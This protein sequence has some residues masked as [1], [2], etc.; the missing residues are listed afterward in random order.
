MDPM[1][2][3]LL[4]FVT[5]VS[6]T[7]TLTIEATND[8]VTVREG[9]PFSLSCSI[10]LGFPGVRE[11]RWYRGSDQMLY[12]SIS[13]T[14]CGIKPLCQE[15]NTTDNRGV[16]QF[17]RGFHNAATLTLVIDHSTAHDNTS[18][19]CG[20]L[21]SSNTFPRSDNIHVIVQH[22]PDPSY[23]MCLR[24]NSSTNADILSFSCW[25]EI[26]QPVV[27]LEW[28]VEGS[29]SERIS[30]SHQTEIYE[31]RVENTLFLNE[32]GIP[33]G[34]LVFTCHMTSS[35]FPQIQ[36]NCSIEPILIPV[37]Q[38]T[39]SILP[40]P[41]QTTAGFLPD[42]SLPD[43]TTT[44][45]TTTTPQN[46][47]GSTDRATT[48]FSQ[49]GMP[50]TRT[51]KIITQSDP[52]LNTIV[53][54]ATASACLVVIIILLI[55]IACL[56]SSRRTRRKGEA[57]TNPNDLS[58]RLS[59]AITSPGSNTNLS[60]EAHVY[61]NETVP[62]LSST[63]RPGRLEIPPWDHTA[64]HPPSPLY[65]AVSS[66]K[67]VPQVGDGSYAV[68]PKRDKR[69]GNS[70]LEDQPNMGQGSQDPPEYHTLEPGV[71]QLTQAGREPESTE[72]QFEY[73]IPGQGSRSWRSSQLDE[74]DGKLIDNVLYTTQNEY[75]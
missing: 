49:D 30:L 2:F 8:I 69:R 22:L 64:S 6:R 45:T 29:S 52:Q 17:T 51:T 37:G 54:A 73:A 9:E 50:T 5:T 19:Y 74:D 55:I 3:V 70:P 11:V 25:A 26:T 16:V 58:I 44:T 75:M 68:V 63:N 1:V 35:A 14:H 53:I 24:S 18:F 4:L 56:V 13:V 66:V 65:A 12:G 21:T 20:L 33:S 46:D 23:P 47:L 67:K 15:V 60:H 38:T 28:T 40:S 57:K 39:A 59:V 31:N 7:T 32:T 42:P 48:P 72:G 36:I 10:T 43:P 62:A 41:E 27:S 61:A 71:R 34:S